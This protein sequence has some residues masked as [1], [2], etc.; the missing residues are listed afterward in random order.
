MRQAAATLDP[1]GVDVT[2]LPLTQPGNLREPRGPATKFLYASGSRPLDG[3]T[4][5]RGIGRGGFGEVYYATSDGGKE[6]ALKLIRRNLDVELRGVAHCLNL[7][8]P[9]LLALYDTRVD[10]DGDTWVV[11]EYLHGDTLDLAIAEHP[12]GM[13][14]NE[15]LAWLH[16]I[17]GGVGYLH[18]HGIV[19][20]DL[21]PGNIFCDEGIV[22][23]GDYGLSKFISTSRRSGQT[24]SV[25]TV[26]YMAPEVANGRYGKEIDIYALG[27]IL[28]EMLTGRV[29]FEG[30]SVGEVLMKHLTANP[31]V[32]NIAEPFR[33]VVARMLDKDPAKRPQSVSELLSAL[34][35]VGNSPVT[36]VSSAR[37]SQLPPQLPPS[38]PY[39]GPAVAAATV[40]SAT[41]ASTLA[42]E[43]PIW[44]AV[45]ENWNEIYKAW[46]EA[47]LNFFVRFVIVLLAVTVLLSTT[48]VWVPAILIYGVYVGVRSIV[49][50]TDNST[51]A[52]AP[53]A[54]S[55]PP[56]SAAPPIPS[57]APAPVTATVQVGLRRFAPERPEPVLPVKTPR[58]KSTEL[59]T[60]MI[61]SALVALL[62]CFVLD[63]TLM[64]LDAGRMA[65]LVL[66][67]ASGA[68]GVM[69]CS[70]FWEGEQG[71]GD[72]SRR[73]C[74]MVL[75]GLALGFSAWALDQVLM[76]NW[77][78]SLAPRLDIHVPVHGSDAAKQLFKGNGGPS[79]IGYLAYFGILFL[80]LRW[81]KLADPL[82]ERRFS[83]WTTFVYGL[84]AWVLSLFWPFPD[85]DAI[86]LAV[87][88]ALAVQF[89]S[90]WFDRRAN[91]QWKKC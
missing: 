74:V 42:G 30:E 19:H 52:A 89:A 58:E 77:T 55:I 15:V 20:R 40:G 43:E 4:I 21:K 63:T 59:L 53:V 82:R 6:V 76:V 69:I 1:D 45:K 26:H 28:Y 86:A 72:E 91:K 24:E 50:T 7:K 66:V 60:S 32:S 9:N 75:A 46:N 49:I 39:A 33:S 16:G 12:Q 18:D 23:L 61:V 35:S 3:Y 67:T 78:Y 71:P 44:K 84:W 29:P 65:W 68:W 5:K 31:D 70:K 81:W 13:P 62:S 8:H 57:A 11:M 34:P 2:N 22:K 27:V 36:F 54:P 38:Q 83:I 48:W 51:S 41:A 14:V 85:A 73:R 90:P 80:G 88:I 56:E 79:L 64:D 10:S 25:G 37:P 87:S 17:A 47:N